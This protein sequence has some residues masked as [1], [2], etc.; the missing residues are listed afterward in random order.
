MTIYRV[1][2]A[3][4]PLLTV[5]L[6]ALMMGGKVERDPTNAVGLS[7]TA[8]VAILSVAGLVGVVVAYLIEGRIRADI[9]AL[10]DVPRVTHGRGD[11]ESWHR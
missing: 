10:S 1:V 9:A 4:V 3:A 6:L 7:N 5:A 2:A 11:S 8:A